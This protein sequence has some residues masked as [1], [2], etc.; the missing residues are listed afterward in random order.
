MPLALQYP[1]KQVGTQAPPSGGP[2]SPAQF[3]DKSGRDV[4][5]IFITGR[6]Y[7]ETNLLSGTPDADANA[8]L[9]NDISSRFGGFVVPP[10]FQMLDGLDSK[11]STDSRAWFENF[12][13]QMGKQQVIETVRPLFSFIQ[14]LVTVQNQNVQPLS[15]IHI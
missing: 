9:W 12:M 2:E 3:A 10:V 1:I 6:I 8:R 5:S 13:V 4:T 11:F 7:P 14:V 15:L